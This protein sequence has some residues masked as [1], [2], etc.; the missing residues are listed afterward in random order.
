MEVHAHT[1]IPTSREKKWAHYFWEFLMLFLAVFCGFLAEY[2]LEHKIEKDRAKQYIISLYEDLKSDTTRINQLL[3]YNDKKITALNN[4]YACY[5]TVSKDL[6]A[7]ACM[8]IL[9]IHSRSNRGFVLTDRTLKQLANAG[10][11]R[12]LSKEDADSIIVYENMYKGY[13][14]F[15]TTVFQ[16]SQDNVRNTLN[17]MADFKVLAP[18]QLTTATFLGDTTSS[19]FSGPL[20]F[21]DDAVLLNKW[22]NEL[23][24]YLR[25]TNGQRNSMIQLKNKATDLIRYYKEKHHF[26]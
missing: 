26:E 24:M 20:L 2:Q 16:Q 15:Q 11:Y 6:K 17:Q 25:T 21:S 18:H 5:D 1:H 4:M 10:G 9:I 12:L 13:L 7:T 22:F 23:A 19:T 14:D 3:A 8:G